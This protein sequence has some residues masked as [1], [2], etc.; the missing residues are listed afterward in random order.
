MLVACS[1]QFVTDVL[2]RSVVS[3][4]RMD[5]DGGSGT[6]QLLLKFSEYVESTAKVIRR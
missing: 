5:H 3:G 1:D 4:K 2:D 6:G